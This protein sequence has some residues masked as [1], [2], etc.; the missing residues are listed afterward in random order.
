MHESATTMFMKSK[1]N[2]IN[3]ISA[4]YT[5]YTHTACVTDPGAQSFEPK[6][7]PWGPNG[8]TTHTY[9]YIYIQTAA[10]YIMLVWGKLR[11]APIKVFISLE[12]TSARELHK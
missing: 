4:V 6:L 7:S 1:M 3:G 2:D 12:C 8:Y 5:V 9:K 10:T 11:L